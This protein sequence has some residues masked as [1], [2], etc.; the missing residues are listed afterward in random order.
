MEI[1]ECKKAYKSFFA[2]VEEVYS[3]AFSAGE[4]DPNC[5]EL[6]AQAQAIMDEGMTAYDAG[7]LTTEEALE[8]AIAK[9]I[10]V[11]PTTDEN[12]AYHVANTAQYAAFVDMVNG[13]KNDVNLIL[14][15]D[16]MMNTSMVMGTFYGDIDG[17]DHTITVDIV[18]TADNGA[19]ISSLYSS[20][21]QNLIIRGTITTPYKYAAGVAAHTYDG[22]T[23]DRIQSYVDIVGTIAG[24]ATHG[25]I[26][27][28][29]ESGTAYVNN[30]VFAGSMSGTGNSNGGIVGWSSATSVATGCLVIANITADQTNGNIIGRNSTQANN[31]Y[32]V[33]AYGSAP[34]GATQIEEAALLDGSV[35]YGLNGGSTR[36]D[37]VWR[38]DLGT[39][40]LPSLDPT[41]KIV[42]VKADGTFTNEIQNEIEKYNGTKDDPYILKTT[43]DM[44]LLRSFLVPGRV[45]YVKLGADIDMAEITE[46]YPLNMEEDNA[47]GLGYQ[48]IIDFDG[49]GHV[50]SNFSC[51]TEDGSYNSFFGILNGEVRNVGFKD[52]NVSCTKSGTGI[53]AGY[54]GHDQYMNADY[55]KKASSLTNVWVTGKL[56]VAEGYA[57]GMIGNVG[58]PTN[59]KD[60]YTNIEITSEANYIGGIVGRVRDELNIDGAYAAGSIITT[61]SE[62]VGGII[63]GGQIAAT[64]RGYYNDIVVWNNTDQNFGATIAPVEK[65]LPTADVLDVVFNEDG[66]ATDKSPMQ[67]EITAM[68]EPKVQY[69]DKFGCNVFFSESNGTTPISWYMINYSQNDAMKAALTDGYTMETTFALH[70]DAITGTI[71]PFCATESGGFG[72]EMPTAG[73]I[74]HIAYTTVDGAGGYKSSQSAA[75]AKKGN[76]YHVVGVYDKANK[77]VAVYVNGINKGEVAA[78]GELTFPTKE[79]SQWIG[80]GADP[81]S[82]EN[83]GQS[84]ANFEI[85]NAR[86]YNEPVSEDVAKAL[87]YNQKGKNFFAGDKMG[88]ISYYNG[89]NFAELQGV[90]VA[91]GSPWQCDMTEGTYPTFDGTLADGINKV[92]FDNKGKIFNINGIQVEKTT[93]GLYIIDGKKVMVK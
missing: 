57:G 72:I 88:N 1:I 93:K 73:N 42:Y 22:C 58:G 49:Q 53:L 5:S 50:I 63:G 66:T 75:I 47:N 24:D 11:Y 67:N 81:S 64:D 28:V 65:A 12:G 39:D 80:I 23:F 4:I 3:Y 16:V 26:V 36:K 31:C 60:C 45:N 41:H 71:K 25:G 10:N 40:I 77:K 62:N 79:I 20:H 69:S 46:W 54:M 59:I 35:T 33:T 34:T 78:D 70:D 30:S 38:Q 2:K 92:T 6:G 82:T 85:I 18:P 87:Y 74:K 43:Q 68:G 48:N 56:N 51:T 44:A 61:T 15:G 52:A 14:D 76:Y 91:W 84:G 55:T 7:T 27:A 19:M 13:G 86:I 29:N 17:Q 90:V 32:Y 37:V 83:V 89:S 21:V 8:C 9:T